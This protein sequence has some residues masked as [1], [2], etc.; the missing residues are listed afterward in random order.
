MRPRN[1]QKTQIHQVSGAESYK[2]SFDK[3]T[4]CPS[5]LTVELGLLKRLNLA[6]VDV[7]HRVDALHSLEDLSG[8]V[9]GNAAQKERKMKGRQETKY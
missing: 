6:D 9:L 8:D 4:I 3:M 2:R 5:A 7:L 1:K